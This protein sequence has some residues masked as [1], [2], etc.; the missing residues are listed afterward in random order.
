MVGRGLIVA[1]M[2]R[3]AD[4]WH[5]YLECA[6]CLADVLKAQG[7]D[8][9]IRCDPDRALS[10]IGDDVRLLA[11]LVGESVDD[12]CTAPLLPA[13]HGLDGYLD[14]G[15]AVLAMHSAA[16]AFAG[17]ARW[18]D[19]IGARW[20]LD[21]S[22]HPPLAWGQVAVHSYP[23]SPTETSEMFDVY[24]ELYAGLR[25]SEDVV[26]MATHELAGKCHPLI[27]H[28]EYCGG[29]V[30]YDAL[31]HDARSYGAPGHARLLARATGWLLGAN[32]G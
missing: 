8:P 17:Y 5:R 3:Y 26:P 21:Q 32:G 10:E 2:G 13:Q 27:W 18:E 19:A 11:I 23:D 31:G 9:D 16:S 1:G 29:R 22:W 12:G 28:R 20:V 6:L 4:P 14:S 15:R 30:V 25:I 24:D 7:L